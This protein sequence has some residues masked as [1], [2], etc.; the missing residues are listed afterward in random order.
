MTR[1]VDVA[2]PSAFFTFLG[3][4]HPVVIFFRVSANAA[5]KVNGHTI[6]TDIALTEEMTA[7]TCF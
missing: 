3:F 5:I 2:H 7:A 1:V 6:A 4:H